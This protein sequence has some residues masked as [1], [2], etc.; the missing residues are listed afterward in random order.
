MAQIRLILLAIQFLTRLPTPQIKDFKDEYL[1]DAG[2]W[3]P[4][5][6]VVIGVFLAAICWSASLLDIWLAAWLGLLTWVV[7]TGGLHLDGIA[8]VADALGAA[9]RDKERLLAVMKD[10]HLGSF[11]V[12]TLVVVVSGKLVL[13]MLLARHQ[14]WFTLVLIPAWARWGIYSWQSLPALAPGMAERFSWQ[15][16][17]H[18]RLLWLVLLSAASLYLAPVLVVAPILVYLYRRWLAQTL[19]GVSGDCLGAG[20]EVVELGLLLAIAMVNSEG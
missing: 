3:F 11:G 18:A 14:A 9:H 5:V 19:G 13:L 1:A 10:P 2:R 8:D 15:S 16:H 12:L 4:L 7:I 20:V 6:G 17:R